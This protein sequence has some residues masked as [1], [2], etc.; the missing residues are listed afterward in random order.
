MP[1]TTADLDPLDR[2]DRTIDIDAPAERVW[3]LVARPGWWINEG[4]VDPELDVQ[5]EGDITVLT[6]PTYGE[7]RLR[8]VESHPTSYVAYHWLD[9][10][11]DAPTL[12]EFR[13][14]PREAGGV[15]LSVTESGF[16]RLGKSREEWLKHREG[17]DEGW[18]DELAVAKT[19]VEGA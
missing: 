5:T 18:R 14:E 12:V 11:V 7:F 2:I 6:H 9:V 17:N 1:D 13:I 8:T 3:D 16:S 19:Y 4:A 15:T 10:A